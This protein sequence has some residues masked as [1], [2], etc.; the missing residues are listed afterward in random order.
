MSACI[1]GRDL[2]IYSTSINELSRRNAL[3]GAGSRRFQRA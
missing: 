2:W 3:G 1:Y